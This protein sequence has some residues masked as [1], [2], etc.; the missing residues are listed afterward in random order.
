MGRGDCWGP[1]RSVRAWPWEVGL[2]WLETWPGSPPPLLLFYSLPRPACTSV[3]ASVC[4]CVA[5]PCPATH[6]QR[7]LSHLQGSRAEGPGM[8]PR[9]REQWSDP[10]P[11]RHGARECPAAPSA[12][13]G[14][15]R[16]R[17]SGGSQAAKGRGLP[18]ESWQFL[19]FFFLFLP[20]LFCFPFFF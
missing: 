12:T 2:C 6:H 14:G 10:P 1:G 3:H 4:V 20:F 9:D 13:P 8:S 19:L 17:T 15:L 7:Q 18:R 16:G 11:S 5:V